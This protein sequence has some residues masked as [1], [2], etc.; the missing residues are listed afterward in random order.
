[1]DELIDI[2]QQNYNELEALV[3]NWK[4]RQDDSWEL[5]RGFPEISGSLYFAF[6]NN[7]DKMRTLLE[8]LLTRKTGKKFRTLMKKALKGVDRDGSESLMIGPI[9]RIPRYKIFIQELT[10]HTYVK[11]PLRERYTE[12][13]S[14]YK[15][16]LDTINSALQRSQLAKQQDIDL[17]PIVGQINDEVRSIPDHS[18]GVQLITF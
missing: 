6:C 7:H 18:E 12:V 13:L 11:H 5:F 3:D 16:L 17:A 1:M 9:Q 2:H 14:T 10:K 8:Q 15:E 4:D